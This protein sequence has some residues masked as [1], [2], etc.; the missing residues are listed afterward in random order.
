VEEKLTPL[1][2]GGSTMEDHSLFRS[3]ELGAFLIV[4]HFSTTSISQENIPLQCLK[5]Q[6]KAAMGKPISQHFFFGDLE[7]L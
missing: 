6:S 4:S 1:K 2:D 7:A 5:K 3:S